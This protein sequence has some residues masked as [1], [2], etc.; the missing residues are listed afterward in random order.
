MEPR[1]LGPAEDFYCS[2]NP[3]SSS[4][5]KSRMTT[6]S[7]ALAIVFMVSL[8]RTLLPKEEAS[9]TRRIILLFGDDRVPSIKTVIG[10]V[11]ATWFLGSIFKTEAITFACR[12]HPRTVRLVGRR[13]RVQ[14]RCSH[15]RIRASRSFHNSR[16]HL[17][18]RHCR[19]R[20]NKI[21]RPSR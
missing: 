15:S 16:L 9:A 20:R 18:R 3:Q 19:V 6:I 8:Y 11:G 17:R 13:A 5:T 21:R 1:E 2:H 14:S 7:A 12:T 10:P 4:A